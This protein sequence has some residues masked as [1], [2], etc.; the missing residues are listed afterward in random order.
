MSNKAIK[1]S[2]GKE[3]FL[4]L[5]PFFFLFHGY[6][7]NFPL[8]SA[9]DCLWLCLKY[10]LATALLCALFYLLFR[11][12]RKAAIMMLLLMCFYFFFGSAHDAVKSIAPSTFIAR[13]S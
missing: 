8:I 9:E 13:Y 11:S 12:W 6:T 3:Y 4:L 7:E 2:A 5:L 10:L 1:P